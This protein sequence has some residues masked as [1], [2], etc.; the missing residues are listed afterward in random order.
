MAV[1]MLKE[2]WS[3]IFWS[4]YTANTIDPMLEG[5]NKLSKYKAMIEKARVI[6]VFLY[7]YHS[8]LTLMRSFPN[9]R[10]LVRP[11]ITRFTITFLI[12]SCLMNKKSQLTTMVSS[13]K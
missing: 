9:R 1:S 10:E 4:N 8:T 13:D 7:E 12:L 3:N 2:K 6:T 11:G 5:I